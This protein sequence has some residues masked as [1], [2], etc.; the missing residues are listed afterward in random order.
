LLRRALHGTSVEQIEHRTPSNPVGNPAQR[1]TNTCSG[2]FGLDGA[3]KGP[4]GLPNPYPGG[5]RSEGQR[6]RGFFWTAAA[7]PETLKRSALLSERRE[8]GR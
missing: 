2:Y 5:N 7:G 6:R 3:F 8:C 1:T 4:L